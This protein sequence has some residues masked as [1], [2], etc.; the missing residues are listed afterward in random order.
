LPPASSAPRE[1]PEAATDRFNANSPGDSSRQLGA[2]NDS[3]AT[4]KD[5]TARRAA[6][7]QQQREEEQHETDAATAK[8]L[9]AASV[10][11]LD[12]EARAA[13]PAAGAAAPQYARNKT[14]ELSQ[15]AHAAAPIEITSPDPTVR[16]RIGAAGLVERSTNG[17]TTWDTVPAGARADLTAGASPS[18]LVCWI[19]GREGTVR[20]STDGRSLRQ[21]S[22]PEKVDLAAVQATDART[23]TITTADARRFR[24]TDGGVTWV[25]LQGF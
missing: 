16:W 20:V 11:R 25:V 8:Q 23:A 22:F 15:Q 19:V 18:P 10:D 9:Q 21:V 17:G 5:K 1:Q 24:T 3:S 7:T 2:S 14:A 13:A 12:A 4:A 6:P